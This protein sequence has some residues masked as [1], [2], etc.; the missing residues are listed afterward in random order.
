MILDTDCGRV[1]RFEDTTQSLWPITIEG[2]FPTLETEWL[3]FLGEPDGRLD[4]DGEHW[5]IYK[6]GG[7]LAMLPRE[8][9]GEIRIAEVSWKV[10]TRL[11][12]NKSYAGND[13]FNGTLE[14]KHAG[15]ALPKSIAELYA[16]MLETPLDDLLMQAK[17]PSAVKRADSMN[18][19]VRDIIL[20]LI[21]R[22][23]STGYLWGKKALRGHYRWSTM[24][25]WGYM[26]MVKNAGP[27]GK[28]QAIY[29]FSDKEAE[30]YIEWCREHIKDKYPKKGAIQS[31][32][33]A[34]RDP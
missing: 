23:T 27:R 33:P 34:A 5:S 26:F 3:T 12:F 14:G 7:G 31:S 2:P 13:I 30:S 21:S 29:R 28:I 10:D 19:P 15:H 1:L 22:E 11:R 32:K 25:V 6:S 8:G 17:D 24:E 20:S 18:I 4:Q 9:E 16:V